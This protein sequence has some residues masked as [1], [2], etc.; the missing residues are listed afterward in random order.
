MLDHQN[1]EEYIDGLFL[2]YL[3][4]VCHKTRLDVYMLF[5]IEETPVLFF[6]L[7]VFDL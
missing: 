4:F 5:I 2:P 6:L 7:T 1:I 3:K